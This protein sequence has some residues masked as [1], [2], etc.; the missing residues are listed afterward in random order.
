LTISENTLDR[1]VTEGIL[2]VEQATRLRA[3]EASQFSDA[4][5]EESA[6]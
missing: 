6:G 3:L 5:N 2:S 1:A 4:V